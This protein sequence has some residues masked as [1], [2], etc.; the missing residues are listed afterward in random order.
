MSSV[1]MKHE[2]NTKMYLHHKLN[3]AKMLN[4]E[5]QSKSEFLMS[6]MRCILHVIECETI[7][8]W[9]LQHHSLVSNWFPDLL[10]CLSN[11]FCK[12]KSWFDQLIP[13]WL[14][15]WDSGGLADVFR[16]DKQTEI[17]QISPCEQL[18]VLFHFFYSF[19]F[20]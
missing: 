6:L 4:K 17:M 7:A 8:A 15:P 13:V 20:I 16:A 12:I 10:S 2:W 5:Q 19:T 11:F 9:F 14:V 3:R 1:I 18:E